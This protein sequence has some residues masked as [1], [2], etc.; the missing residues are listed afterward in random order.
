MKD[1][2]E[3]GT[4]QIDSLAGNPGPIGSMRQRWGCAVTAPLL[5]IMAV[6]V[7][8]PLHASEASVAGQWNIMVVP[9]RQTAYSGYARERFEKYC[10]SCHSKDGRAQTPVARQ[11]GVRDLSEST[12]SDEEIIEQILHGTHGKEVDFRMPSFRERLGRTSIEELVPVVKAFRPVLPHQEH[13]VAASPRLAGIINFPSRKAAVL[14]KV[15]RSG[16]Y[17]LL[18]VN[19]S[20]AGIELAGIRPAQGTVQLRVRGTNSPLTLKLDRELIHAADA[21]APGFLRRIFDSSS[22]DRH[23]LAL[24]Q[25]NMDLVLFLYSQFTGRTVLRSPRLPATSF[26]LNATGSDQGQIARCLENALTESGVATI[27]DGSKFVFVVLASEVSTITPRSSHIVSLEA[28]SNR[29]ALFRGGAFINFPDAEMSEVVKFYVGLA[30]RPLDQNQP[31]PSNRIVKFT[32]Q[33][34]LTREECAYVLENL[35]G[36]QG[37]QLVPVG[38]GLAGLV[39]ITD[40]GK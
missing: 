23:A 5:V 27:P 9:A 19:E 16:Q 34:A 11:R 4:N 31:F 33:S 3:A 1:A 14:E 10:A 8:L 29:A 39:P 17:F 20:H 36:M 40:N 38:N 7:G 13:P 30:S 35:I 25:A 12:L 32:S 24:D 37:L 22:D 26:S 28:D 2:K 18:G 15:A 21:K 6:G